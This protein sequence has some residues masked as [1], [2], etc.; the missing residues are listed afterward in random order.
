MKNKTK[1][2]ETV[3]LNV[4]YDRPPTGALEID[5]RFSLRGT[6]EHNSRRVAWEF[7]EWLNSIDDYDA[8]DFQVLRMSWIQSEQIESQW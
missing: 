7:V 1:S 8:T 2:I 5:I 4:A 3:P 6:E